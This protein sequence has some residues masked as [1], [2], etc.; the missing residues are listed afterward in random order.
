MDTPQTHEPFKILQGWEYLI[1]LDLKPDVGTLGPGEFLSPLMDHNIESAKADWYS[2]PT[3]VKFGLEF[4]PMD[5]DELIAYY[6]FP[7]TWACYTEQATYL[8]SADQIHIDER[9]SYYDLVGDIIDFEMHVD[10][11]W[12]CLLV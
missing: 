8:L 3:V 10:K 5:E 12:D 11:V 9:M 2:R 7:G 6:G 4:R 1:S